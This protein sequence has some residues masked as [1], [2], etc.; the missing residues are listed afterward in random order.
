M[1]QFLPHDAMQ[2]AVMRQEVICPSV[3]PA[4]CPWHSWSHRLEFFRNNFMAE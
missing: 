1:C 2:S 4:V 3:S